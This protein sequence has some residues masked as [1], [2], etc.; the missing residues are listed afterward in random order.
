M[1]RRAARTDANH[2]TVVAA[3]RKFGCSVLQ[4]F[5]VGAGCPDILIAKNKKSALIEIKDGQKAKSARALTADEEKFHAD[6]QG[7]IFVV[8]D[9]SDVIAVVNWI[10]RK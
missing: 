7:P 3:F 10:E 9:L 4:L 8:N 2:K 1:A 5:M 6:W